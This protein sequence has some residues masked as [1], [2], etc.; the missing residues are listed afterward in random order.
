MNALHAHFPSH[1]TPLERGRLERLLDRLA[2]EP[3]LSRVVVFGSR[4]RGRSK[5]DSDLDLAVYFTSP[6]SRDLERWLDVQAAASD[7]DFGAPQLQV[8]P[9]FTGEPPSR[10]DSALKREGIVLWTKN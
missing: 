6:R 10:L 5:E 2:A 3:R 9:F 4:A 1:L 8:V 7:E